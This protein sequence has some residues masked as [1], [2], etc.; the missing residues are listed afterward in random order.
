[1]AVCCA[2]GTGRDRED[3]GVAGVGPLPT[4][5]RTRLRSAEDSIGSL[6]S[7]A[8]RG[9][10]GAGDEEIGLSSEQLQQAAAKM[11]RAGLRYGEALR[12]VRSRDEALL[13]IYPISRFSRPTPQHEKNRR[14]L[15]DDPDRGQTVIGVALVFPESDSAATIEYLVGSV[16]AL[17]QAGV[18]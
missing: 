5:V 4:I 9:R 15:F 2:G 10:P 11:E 14:L 13:L 1:M 3:L 17:D 7:P 12:S 6:V 16:G 18:G 8:N